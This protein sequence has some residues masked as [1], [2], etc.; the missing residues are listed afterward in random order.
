MRQLLIAS[1]VA[2]FIAAVVWLMPRTQRNCQPDYL[3]TEYV[4]DG[5]GSRKISTVCTV[6]ADGEEMCDKSTAH[7]S[8]Y[9]FPACHQKHQ[10]GSE[11]G[12]KCTFRER[13]PE[14]G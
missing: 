14:D 6:C 1:A 12:E 2:S 3:R 10:Q 11:L 9:E 13:L 5:T 8:R 7:L 4:T